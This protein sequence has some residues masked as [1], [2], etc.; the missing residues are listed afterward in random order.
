MATDY[1]LFIH[2][3]NTRQFDTFRDQAKNLFE[4]IQ[5]SVN[6]PNR[7]LKPIYLFWGNVGEGGTN[8]LEEG[9]K[10]SPKWKDFW[11]QN[12]RTE[13]VLPFVG[14]AALYLSRGVSSQ[15]VQQITDQA[16]QQMGLTLADLANS[17]SDDRLHLVTHSWGTIILFD[18]LFAPRWDEESLPTE[19]RQLVS[20][21]RASFFGLGTEAERNF[22][23]PIASI[24]T[25]GSPIAL[26]SLLNLNPGRSFNLTSN[27]KLMLETLYQKTGRKLPWRNY[28]HPADPIAYPLEGVMPLLLSEAREKVQV[29]DVISKANWLMR[30]FGQTLLPLINGGKAHGSYWTDEKVAESIGQVI[31]STNGY[32][33]TTT[34]PK[35][36]GKEPVRV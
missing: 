22:G 2:G 24:H 34:E 29:E 26:F 27:L 12:L 4:G 35:F 33:L 11:F 30:P 1:V 5:A 3:V 15:I 6:T 31:R 8:A 25:M 14:D 18:V 9:L 13:Q 36:V 19:T 32:N 28:A 16:M 20:H 10:S 7:T 17:K 23:I 21:L